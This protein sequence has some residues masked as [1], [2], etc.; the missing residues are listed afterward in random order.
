MNR[1]E[2]HRRQYEL[3]GFTVFVGVIS[4]RLIDHMNSIV[5]S[6]SEN[7]LVDGEESCHSWH[8]IPLGTSDALSAST[9]GSY[10]ATVLPTAPVRNVQWLNVYGVDEYIG[11]HVDAGGEAQLMIPIEMPPAGSGGEIWIGAREML[12]PIGVGDAL[13]F[14]AHRLRHGT[15][16][17]G[18]RRRVSLNVRMWLS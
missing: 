15:T 5:Q 2:F 16:A 9:L 11:H 17:V 12:L 8:E 4:K 1:G 10:L 3:Q 6:A 13:L 7:D 18:T 14:A